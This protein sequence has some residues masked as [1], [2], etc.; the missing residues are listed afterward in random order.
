MQSKMWGRIG[1]MAIKLDMSKAYDRVKCYFLLEVMRVMGFDEKW[2]NLVM[3][4]VTSINYS[5]LV[6]GASEG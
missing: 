2:I 5:I 1:F 3:M 4:C 6:N